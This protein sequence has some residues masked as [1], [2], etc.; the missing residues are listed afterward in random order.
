MRRTA[1]EAKMRVAAV[2]ATLALAAALAAAPVRAEPERP[3]SERLEETIRGLMDSVK[4]TLDE[5]EG[6]FEMFQ[7]I[8]SLEHYQTPEVLPNGDIIIRRKP[9]AP[10]YLPGADNGPGIRT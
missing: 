2:L 8:D 10:T 5:L 9:D 1:E 6:M 7:S 4:P 3:L